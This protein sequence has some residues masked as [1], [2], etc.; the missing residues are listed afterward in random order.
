[1]KK[2]SIQWLVCHYF[3]LLWLPNIIQNYE[4]ENETWLLNG[5]ECSYRNQEKKCIFMY[6]SN[7]HFNVT[8][9]LLASA[10]FIHRQIFYASSWWYFV[11]F[12]V[13]NSS[14]LS[15]KNTVIK[16]KGIYSSVIWIHQT[17]TKA[18]C[19]KW[20]YIWLVSPSFSFA[21][22]TLRWLTSERPLR[23]SKFGI[24][25]NIFHIMLISV[26]NKCNTQIW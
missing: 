25:N 26:F 22:K 19:E 17:T 14:T 20:G 6:E 13:P 5:I 23:K 11:A 3:P 4:R 15:K 24:F 10:G 7:W 21:H 8:A 16:G 12:L 2:S 9:K 18:H 1:M